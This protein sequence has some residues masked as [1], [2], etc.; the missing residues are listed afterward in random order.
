MGGYATYYL[1]GKYPDIFA[2]LIPICGGVVLPY[3]D[4]LPVVQSAG[5]P[6]Q[7]AAERLRSLP[8]WIFHGENDR[9]VPVQ[10]SRKMYAAL[11]NLGSAVEFT[12]YE[13]VGHN[14]WDRAYAEAELADW[15][16]AQKRK[17]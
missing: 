1:G 13:G 2:A 17:D 14:S 10:E 16:F 7:E 3:G 8:I 9:R 11:K 4:R 6:Y 5:D 15:L 12:E